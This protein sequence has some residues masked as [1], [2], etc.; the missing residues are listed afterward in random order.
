MCMITAQIISSCG[1]N[2]KGV[3]IGQQ[4][5]C[6]QKFVWLRE[7]KR[8]KRGGVVV[9][10]NAQGTWRS[11]NN[12]PPKGCNPRTCYYS[13]IALVIGHYQV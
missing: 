11:A 9:I 5:Q 7:E 10:D 6:M 8:R 13:W 12:G 1:D 4:Y 3:G 2:R